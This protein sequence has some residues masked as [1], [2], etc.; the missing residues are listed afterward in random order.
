Q[1]GGNLY[2]AYEVVPEPSTY[3]LVLLAAG[4]ALLWQRRR[5]SL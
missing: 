2:V 3:A 5:R 4:A 1:E